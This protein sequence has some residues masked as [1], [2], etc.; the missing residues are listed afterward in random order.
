MEHTEGCHIRKD[1]SLRLCLKKFESS[2]TNS[3]TL[4]H[5]RREFKP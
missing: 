4:K 1:V 2:Q 3:D 5:L